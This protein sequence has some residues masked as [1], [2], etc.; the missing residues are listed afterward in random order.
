MLWYVSKLDYAAEIFDWQQSTKRKTKENIFY[1]QLIL[2]H[3][4]FLKMDSEQAYV[5]EEAR[6]ARNLEILSENKCVFEEARVARYL[7]L[8]LEGKLGIADVMDIL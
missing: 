4:L 5:A 8:L 1:L 2:L 7:E 6:V 3:V